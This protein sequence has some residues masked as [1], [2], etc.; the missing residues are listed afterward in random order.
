MTV[1]INRL[2]GKPGII[3]SDLAKL[4]EGKIYQEK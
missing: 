4:G 3:P 2:N 1:V